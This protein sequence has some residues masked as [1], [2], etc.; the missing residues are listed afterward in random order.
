VFVPV[1]VAL[2]AAGAT[3]LLSLWV[4]ERHRVTEAENTA[5]ALDQNLRAADD[6]LDRSIKDGRY[7]FYDLNVNIP[8]DDQKRLADEL[9]PY[10]QYVADAASAYSLQFARA[11]EE[12][13]FVQDD[14]VQLASARLKVALG[15]WALRGLTEAPEE[16]LPVLADYEDVYR[17]ETV[18]LV[19]ER[20]YD[21]FVDGD[22]AFACD[23]AYASDNAR[24]M[25]QRE[26]PN[27]DQEVERAEHSPKL[28]PHADAVF[29]DDEVEGE[30]ATVD[31]LNA[32]E[33]RVGTLEW[34]DE[35]GDNVWHLDEVR[36]LEAVTLPGARTGSGPAQDERPHGPG[37]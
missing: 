21:S 2:V 33:G 26:R 8:L 34:T 4:E 15:R 5:R 24:E 31:L 36:D 14:Y 3:T 6:A 35:D 17:E 9:G 20:F 27:C 1:L 19:A 32:T 22:G 10:Y 7:R 23:N 28:H 12:H 37:G 30:I 16:A 11:G 25:M 13:V 18:E 29:D